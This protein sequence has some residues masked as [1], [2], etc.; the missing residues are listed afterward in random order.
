[1]FVCKNFQWNE[2]DG[3][4]CDDFIIIGKSCAIRQPLSPTAD[5]KGIHR[6]DTSN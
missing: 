4:H 2:M 1:M 6:Y 3:G 5:D